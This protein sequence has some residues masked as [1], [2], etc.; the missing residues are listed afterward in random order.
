MAVLGTGIMP[1]GAIGTELT[2]VTRRAF[3]PK[4]IVQIY[5]SSPL[6]ASFIANSQVARG[7][8]SQVSVPVQGTAFVTPQ[9]SD[10]SGGFTQPAI[11]QGAYLTEQNLTLLQLYMNLKY[12]L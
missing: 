7:G 8:A 10:Y 5:N 4:M 9:Y 6:A 3:V 11:Q 1:S 2:Y 12:C